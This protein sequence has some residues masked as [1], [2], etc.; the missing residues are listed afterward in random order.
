[1]RGGDRLLFLPSGTGDV[2][3]HEGR[4]AHRSGRAVFARP[5]RGRAERKPR[6]PCARS[7]AKAV[8]LRAA[9]RWPEGKLIS[10]AGSLGC[11]LAA[12]SI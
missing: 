10:A 6:E 12:Q 11:A 8:A 2:G 3:Q 7:A 9:D 5:R 1:V 4:V